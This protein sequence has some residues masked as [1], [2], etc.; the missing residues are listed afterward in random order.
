MQLCNSLLFFLHSEDGLQKVDTTDTNAEAR[1]GI[2]SDIIDYIQLKTQ[3]TQELRDYKR[4]FMN[5]I[6]KSNYPLR[7]LELVMNKSHT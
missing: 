6:L 2:C 3:E 4:V 1:L 5:A 7:M